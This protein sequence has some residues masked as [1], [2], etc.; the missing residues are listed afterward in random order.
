[1][2]RIQKLL[3]ANRG[4]IACRVMRTA[5]SLGIK[6]V[7]V[8]SDADENSLHVE[9]ADERVHIG[10]ADASDSYLNKDKIVDAATKCNADAIHPGYGFL[11][12]NADFARAVE[13]AGMIFVGPPEIAINVM[14]DKA[15]A[16][17][18]MIEAG[19][20]CIPGYQGEDQTD[21]TLIAEAEKIGFPLM[22]KAAA[23]GGGRG[24]RLVAR[25]KDL[26]QS[27]KLA[28]SE[29]EN[30]FGSAELI[31]EKA[32]MRPRHV[33]IQV[34]GDRFGNI[35]HL[36]ERDCSIQR[37]HQKVIEES[38][39]P[40]MT[41]ELREQMGRA[42]VDAAAAVDYVGAG[43]V[44]FLLD[45][46]GKFY[47]LEMNT[48]LQV[49]HPITELVTGVDLVAQQLRAAEGLPLD[50]DQSDISLKGH[51]IEARLYAEDPENEFLPS[52]GDVALF[53]VPSG[54]GVRVDA[55]IRS[56]DTVSPF[57]DPMVAKIIAYG[58]SREEARRR[59][60]NALGT[61]ALIGPKNNRD[62]L[63]SALSAE[64]FIEGTATTD[65]V[66]HVFG[67]DG[68]SQPPVSNTDKVV[69]AV[70]Y[71]KLQ[72]RDALTKAPSINSELYSWSSYGTLKS[73]YSFVIDE[74]E[75]N[76]SVIQ[77]GSVEM[78]CQVDENQFR[79]DADILDENTA[80]VLIDG[81]VVPVSF[82]RRGRNALLLSTPERSYSVTDLTADLRSDDDQQS[83]G[84]ITAP[85]HGRLLDIFVEQGQAI[86]Q[87]EKLAVLEAMKM[88]HEIL[89]DIDG[90]VETVGASS[91]DQVSA[92][93]L[94]IKIA[95]QEQS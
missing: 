48:R 57:Y 88:Q 46:H 41:T 91:G 42:A 40:V 26:K 70:V 94:L 44:E 10:A 18:A 25:A 23:G 13:S 28:R 27:I 49:E 8:Y 21:E 53:H 33:E 45:E 47:F 81:S 85:M 52:T 17:R 16:K 95:E 76:L 92:G 43:T 90:T 72:Q 22:V 2:R 77:Y 80:S 35:I 54:E 89:A 61:T 86:S 5:K 60:S 87:G 68:Y 78:M 79:V 31:L 83:S 4:E 82:V 71:H 50:I 58:A 75:F 1:M 37:R 66:A 62:F 74:N 73:E 93:D 6:T 12:E 19:V 55:G 14:G 29:S 69:A 51:A 84:V 15:R 56:G 24:M 63:L 64:G 34:L 30:A 65:F 39:C 38:P 67:E 20:P 3:I 7:A 59:L 11:S 36:G 32:I 9:L